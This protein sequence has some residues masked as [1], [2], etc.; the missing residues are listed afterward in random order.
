MTEKK[1]SNKKI[2]LIAI[3]VVAALIGFAS[4]TKKDK[5]NI[6]NNLDKNKEV[7]IDKIKNDIKVSNNSKEIS[8]KEKKI[9]EDIKTHAPKIEKKASKMTTKE[10]AKK[11]FDYLEQ[12]KTIE[13]DL[14]N[15][16]LSNIEDAKKLIVDLQKRIKELEE[17]Q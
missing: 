16:K 4:G 13:E 17:A 6:G 7:K 14:K 15:G 11:K 8:E 10:K 5:N 9:I 2:I 3:L 1:N 12:I